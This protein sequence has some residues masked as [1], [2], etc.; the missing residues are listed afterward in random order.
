MRTSGIRLSTDQVWQ[1]IDTQRATLADLLSGLDPPA[2]QVASLCTGWRVRDVAAHLSLAQAGIGEILPWF[3]RSGLSFNGMVRESAIHLPATN[4]EI[5]ARLRAL[6]GT[7][8][9]APF[10]TTMEPLL[11]VLIHAQDICVPLGI[12]RPMPHDA[13]GAAANRV[14]TLNRRPAIRLRRPPSGVRLVATDTE[15]EWGEGETVRGELRW[16][17]LTL[18]GRPAAQQFLSGPTHLIDH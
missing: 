9:T 11:D 3:L 17:L 7:R 14:V 4:A 13:A 2:W 18:A 12:D 10:V 5:I 15:W 6:I 16:L 8:R 1:H